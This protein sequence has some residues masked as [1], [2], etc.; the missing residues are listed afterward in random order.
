LDE[1]QGNTIIGPMRNR[2]MARTDLSK[3]I[4]Q[5]VQKKKQQTMDTIHLLTERLEKIRL[6]AK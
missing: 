5:I 2:H 6:A 4:E 1:G 3:S